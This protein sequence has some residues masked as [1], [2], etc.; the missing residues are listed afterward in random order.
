MEW[1]LGLRIAHLAPGAG[2]LATAEDRRRELERFTADPWV[3]AGLLN[4]RQ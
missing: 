4:G 1:P 2:S 3:V